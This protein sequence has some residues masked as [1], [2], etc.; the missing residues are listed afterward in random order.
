MFDVPETDNYETPIAIWRSL[1]PALRSVSEIWD[2]FYCNGR[3]KIYWEDL[4]KICHS[5]QRDAFTSDVPGSGNCVIVTN[6]PFSIME[7]CLEWIVKQPCDAYV[8]LPLEV[9]HKEWFH[10]LI[11]S[12]Q[13]NFNVME[14]HAALRNGF[15]KEGKQLPRPRFHYVIVSL[16]TM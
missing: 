9:L 2:P 14:P 12:N 15:I 3:S 7:R 6:P 8:L 4:G 16:T 11:T 10:H 5:E 13:V 1:L